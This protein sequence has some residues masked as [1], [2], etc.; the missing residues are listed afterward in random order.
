MKILLVEDSEDNQT[1]VSR[2]LKGA[3][4]VVELADN[5]LEFVPV[6]VADLA[7]GVQPVVD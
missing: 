3:G 6:L 4:A 5:G 7:N 2:Y 1:L